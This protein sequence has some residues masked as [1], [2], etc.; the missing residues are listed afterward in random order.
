MLVLSK[1]DGGWLWLNARLGAVT[2]RMLRFEASITNKTDLQ[3]LE[4]LGAR[5]VRKSDHLAVMI[6]PVEKRRDAQ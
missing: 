1:L 5:V 2:R 6:R 3:A 4:D